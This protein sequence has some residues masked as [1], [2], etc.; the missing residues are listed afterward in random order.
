MKQQC[1]Q[2]ARIA[3]CSRD[4]GICSQCRRERQSA[5]GSLGGSRACRAAKIRAGRK[6]GQNGAGA[7]KARCGCTNGQS[8]QDVHRPSTWRPL[9]IDATEFGEM[10]QTMHTRRELRKPRPWV[11]VADAPLHARRRCPEEVRAIVRTMRESRFGHP[12]RFKDYV[13]KQI[14]NALA[15]AKTP[16]L[17]AKI[18]VAVRYKSSPRG[19]APSLLSAK[20]RDFCH[21]VKVHKN[22]CS[23]YLQS[24]TTNAQLAKGLQETAVELAARRPYKSWEKLED[25]IAAT[26]LAKC[27]KY[28]LEHFAARQAAA[29]LY[30]VPGWVSGGGPNKIPGQCT[31]G[32]GAL[33]GWKLSERSQKMRHRAYKPCKAP[34]R[35]Q[36]RKQTIL[37]EYH[38]VVKRTRFGWRA[39]QQYKC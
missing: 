28:S 5:G 15:R 20:G 17:Q 4:L 39:Q 26:V 21:T 27:G 3:T 9:C 36:F 22:G 13:S 23:T 30:K 12:D 38:K 18:A 31:L 33:D 37:C 10:L 32:P 35:T 14:L 34:R 29:D 6:G 11:K 7:L 16:E 1:A 19:L 25:K 2:C 24:G 8:K